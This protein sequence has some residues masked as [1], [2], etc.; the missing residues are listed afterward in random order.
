MSGLPPDTSSSVGVPPSR[1]FHAPA[2]SL[3]F[4]AQQT[5]QINQANQNGQQQ[6]GQSEQDISDKMKAM[7][8]EQQQQAAAAAAAQQQQGQAASSNQQP[9][10]K[11]E[12][13]AA[14][15]YAAERVIGNG[16]FGVVYQATV[17]ETGETVAIKKVLQVGP[18]HAKIE[19]KRFRQNTLGTSSSS[20]RLLEH[21]FLCCCRV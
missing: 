11:K 6:Q 12:L 2:P 14:V 17:I 13:G 10:K 5:A 4:S 21:F 7:R 3:A 20:H 19:P 1:P 9:A 15:R 18:S 16:S 8:L